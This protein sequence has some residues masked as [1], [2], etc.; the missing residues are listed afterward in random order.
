M[1]AR[2]AQPFHRF[3]SINHAEDAV[4]VHQSGSDIEMRTGTTD[5][6]EG[7][8]ACSQSLALELEARG[9]DLREVRRHYEKLF[10]RPL[11]IPCARVACIPE[12]RI[13]S[14]LVIGGL[15]EDV[16]SGTRLVI[17]NFYTHPEFRTRGIGSRLYAEVRQQAQAIEGVVGLRLYCRFD[18]RRFEELVREIVDRPDQIMSF[19]RRC[20]QKPDLDYLVMD[21]EWAGPAE[22]RSSSGRDIMHRE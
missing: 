7:L 19:Y 1:L 3:V 17:T 20:G 22:L 21:D 8:V 13:I 9:L 15:E 18:L 2:A 5:D 10:Q 12:G 16:W 4:A 6:I 14:A 11:P